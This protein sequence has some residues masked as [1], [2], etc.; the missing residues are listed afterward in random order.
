LIRKP[1]KD[2]DLKIA[3]CLIIRKFGQMMTLPKVSEAFHKVGQEQ[4]FG[5]M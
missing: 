4:P 2:G 3:K 5:T 1:L